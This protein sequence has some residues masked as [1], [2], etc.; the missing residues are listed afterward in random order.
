MCRT[1]PNYLREVSGLE[2]GRLSLSIQYGR[3]VYFLSI[4]K[5]VTLLT[6]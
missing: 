2:T 1:L 3:M 6:Q 5:A 4:G